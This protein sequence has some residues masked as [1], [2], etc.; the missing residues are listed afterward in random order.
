MR[1]LPDL[2]GTTLENLN[3]SVNRL[4]DISDL[5]ALTSIDTITVSNNNLEFDDLEPFFARNELNYAPQRPK[6][7]EN[8]FLNIGDNYLMEFTT[9]GLVLDY[10]WKFGDFQDSTMSQTSNSFTIT[11]FQEENAGLYTLNITSGFLPD[12]TIQKQ[13]RGRLARLSV[14]RQKQA[15]VKIQAVMRGLRDRKKAHQR[16]ASLAEYSGVLVSCPGTGT[17]QGKKG[18]YCSSNNDQLWYNFDITEEGEWV[19]MLGP[20]SKTLVLKAKGASGLLVNSGPY[21]GKR[22]RIDSKFC[23][24]EEPSEGL[25]G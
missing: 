9:T 11:N 5:V 14:L 10:E 4:E 22:I 13:W 24:T 2:S 23:I 17:L 7:V 18:W 19:L 8:L 20:I 21:Q 16:K 3:V 15:V 25:V 1:T 12:L 6:I